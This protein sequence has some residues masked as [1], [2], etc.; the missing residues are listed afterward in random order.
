MLKLDAATGAA[1]DNRNIYLFRAGA[2]NNQV[3]FTW[4]T[5]PCDGARQPDRGAEHRPERDRAGVLRHCQRLDPEPVPG[6]DRRNGGN[7]RPAHAGGGRQPGQLPARP[8]RTRRLRHATTSTKLYRAREHVL[9]DIVNGQPAYVKAPFAE[10]SDAGYAAFKSANAGRTPMLYVPANDGMLHAFYAGTSAA[11]RAG[12]QGGLGL[13]SDGCAAESLQARRYLLPEPSRV[14]RRRH[15]RRS[16]MSSTVSAWKT[17]LVAGLNGGGKSYY[18]LDVTDPA[19][20][21]GMWE[22]SRSNTCY[23][24]TARPTA[25]APTATSATPTASR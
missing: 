8:A 10:Y 1:C 3:N 11:D 5:Q 2:T 18:A 6:D 14:L 24:G 22:F 19:S 4:G 25:T 23:N 21:K 17:I 7:G 15:A 16:A 9:G 13:H 12:R 20:P